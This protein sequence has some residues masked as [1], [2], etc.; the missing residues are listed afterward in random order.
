[1]I[2]RQNDGNG[3]AGQTAG[4]AAD[5]GSF[6][7]RLMAR[8]AA[9]PQSTLAID[10]GI[11]Y[12][13]GASSTPEA[14][15]AAEAVRDEARQRRAEADA[16]AKAE[17][18]R[19]RA[20]SVVEVPAAEVK[21]P[22]SDD[23]LVSVI[24]EVAARKADEET[25]RAPAPAIIPSAAAAETA[26]QVAEREDHEDI[27]TRMGDVSQLAFAGLAILGLAGLSVLAAQNALREGFSLWVE[28]HSI[29]NLLSSGA[30][31]T[32]V[33]CCARSRI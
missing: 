4:K 6:R 18:K 1:M 7:A 27:S 13:P 33:A 20:A 24:E 30:S 32:G 25:R 14:R 3:T 29:L 5:P 16:A 8:Q 15:R 9:R 22:P 11:V 26:P 23:E 10:S 28:V 2:D 31:D 12:R 21:A 19:M 17:A